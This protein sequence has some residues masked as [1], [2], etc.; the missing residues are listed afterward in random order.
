VTHPDPAELLALARDAELYLRTT[1]GPLRR[2]DVLGQGYACAG[3]LLR[4]NIT[5]ALD[6]G[7]RLDYFAIRRTQNPGMVGR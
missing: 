1:H 5:A 3:C 7:P 4:R 6:D 2:H